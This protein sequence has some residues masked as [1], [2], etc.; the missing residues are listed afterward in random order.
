MEHQLQHGAHHRQPVQRCVHHRREHVVI[1][2]YDEVI[3][4]VVVH[5]ITDHVQ[6][7][8]QQ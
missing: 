6:Y 8:E 5:N 4:I 1:D 3:Q 2:H 7:V